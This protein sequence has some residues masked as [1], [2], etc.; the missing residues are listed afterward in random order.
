MTACAELKKPSS[1]VWPHKNP[2]LFKPPAS[3]EVGVLLRYVM[4]MFEHEK[5]PSWIPGLIVVAIVLLGA[6][7]AVD[8]ATYSA[9][10]GNYVAGTGSQDQ[11]PTQPT[12]NTEPSEVPTAN[13][14]IQ[15]EPF[16]GSANAPVT[17]VEFTDFQCP[18]CKRAHDTNF[19]T[20]KSQYIDTGKVKY[21][22]KDFPL[23]FHTEADEAAN[24]ANCAAEQGKYYE[25]YNKLF[26]AQENWVGS[27]DPNSYF[28][29]LGQGIGL[30]TAT[31]NSCV[32]SN[33]HSAEVQQDISEGG[34]AGV[35]GTPTFFINGKKIV[36]AQPLGAFT[37]ALDAELA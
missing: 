3:I 32:D 37:A 34:A 9:I 23:S 15:G 30:N 29:T 20:I 6:N 17:M 12:G 2:C 22:V 4:R 5:K 26:E 25:M 11:Q 14:D 7:L 8:Y 31:F 24:A 36:G 1:W 28:K 19:A 21:V 18:F 16:F 27:A 35:S 10:T 33:K 13:I